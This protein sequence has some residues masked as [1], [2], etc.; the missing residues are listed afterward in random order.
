MLQSSSDAA[1]TAASTAQ[2]PVTPAANSDVLLLVDGHSLAFRSFFAFA[3]GREGGL[4]TSTGIPTSVCFGFLKAL[5]EVLEREKPKAVAVAFDLSTPTFRHEA[6]ATYKEGRAET[7]QEFIS[8]LANLKEL[9]RSLNLATCS[10]PGFEADDVLGTLSAQG[11]AAG[12]QVKVLS[13]DQDMF[14]LVDPDRRISVLHL[15][16]KDRIAEYGPE[17]VQAKLGIRPDQVVDY[18]AL[19]GDSSDRIP[20]VKGIGEK[21]AVKLLSEYGS[22]DNILAALPEMKG[23]VKK[24]LEEGIESARHSQHLAR[25]VQDVPLALSLDE[26]KLTGFNAQE[27][28]DSLEKLEFQTFVNQIQR[29]QSVFGGAEIPIEVAPRPQA[30]R[31]AQPAFVPQFDDDDLSFFSA[32][33]TEQSQAE[34]VVKIE[35]QIIDTPEKLAALKARLLKHQDPETPIAWDTETTAL[36]PFDATL[37]GLGCCWG[38]TATELA[39][40]P[41]AHTAG[42]TLDLDLVRSELREILESDVYP[43]VLQNAKFDRLILRGQGI[44]LRGVVFDPMLASYLLDPETGHSLSELSLRYLGIQALSYKDLVKDKKQTIADISIPAVADYCGMDVHTTY[45]LVPILREK[46][47]EFTELKQLLSQVE[48]PLEAVLADMEWQGIR[49]DSAYLAEF[50]KA[51]EEDLKKIEIRAYEQAGESFN[52]NSPQQLSKLFFEKLNLDKKKSRRMASGYSTDAAVLDKL[53]GDHPLIDTILEHRTLAKLKSTYVDTLPTLVRPDTHRVH[54]DFNQAITA[55]GRLSSSNPNLQN[56]PIRTAFSRQIRKAFIPE[57]GWLLVAADYS[58]IELRILAH[59]TQEPLLIKT[60]NQNEDVHTL[61]AQLLLGKQEVNSE[62]RRLAKVINY[63]VIYGIGAQRFARESGISIRDAK[64][65]ID[66]FKLRYPAIFEYMK[67]IEDQAQDRGYVE[68]ILG[69]R[70]YFRNLN[71]LGPGQRAALLRAAVNAPIQGTS[72]DIVKI[73]MVNLH[74]YLQAEGCQARLLL[75][76]HDE[77]VLEVPRDE[78]PSLEPQIKQIMESAVTLS[79]PLVADVHAGDNLMEAK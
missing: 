23:A 19:C 56:I 35:P 45:R 68:T 41:I 22:L 76:I 57:P 55:T 20:G 59:L 78:W 48:L 70:R 49:I 33:E 69:R 29:L 10:A 53:Q 40:I 43:K 62:E 3:Y 1:L 14:Q 38:E 25:I 30:K 4:R 12:Y 31:Q 16:S 39:Y 27:V 9:L 51:L 7:P 79:V 54:T 6:D 15:S 2:P 71:S 11:S 61:T 58:Q 28:I 64:A 52:L 5:L 44:E 46:L 36:S 77:L 18:K 66:A 13:G 74:R 37:V 47:A 75:Q 26:C 32:E 73:A 63:G 50:S 65:F 17:Q 60:Y 21:T 8:D 34:P 24:K 42:Q 67:R 72:A